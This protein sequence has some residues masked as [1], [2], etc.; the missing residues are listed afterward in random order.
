[1]TFFELFSQENIKKAF[2]PKYRAKVEI[3]KSKVIQILQSPQAMIINFTAL[4]VTIHGSI[5][6]TIAF[7]L[8]NDFRGVAVSSSFDN[9]AAA[10]Y[11]PQTN[12]ID[13]GIDDN[14]IDWKGYVV[15]E[16]VHAWIDRSRLS[17]TSLNNEATAYIAHLLYL[18]QFGKVF[19]G[20]IYGA[21]YKI[22]NDIAN[23]K[24]PSGNDL[25]ILKMRIINNPTYSHLD[26]GTMAFIDG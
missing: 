21:A 18:R 13:L 14:S 25:A 20:G 6:P 11:H 4:G 15:H 12:L 16:S 3:Y 2:D 19:I 7:D 17:I 23:G 8:Q 9:G 24:T 5:F 10:L 26:V 1:M 22:A